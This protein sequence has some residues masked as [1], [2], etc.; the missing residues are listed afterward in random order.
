[1]DSFPYMLGHLSSTWLLANNRSKYVLA[2][3][4]VRVILQGF[5]ET[6]R[7]ELKA[8]FGAG[9]YIII[10]LAIGF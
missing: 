8:T 9:S 6:S 1:M 3:R 2:S 7:T 10:I 4:T 5:T